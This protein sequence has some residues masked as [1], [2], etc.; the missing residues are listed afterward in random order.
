MT[1]GGSRLARPVPLGLGLF[2]L[3]NSEQVLQVEL[4]KV[5]FQYTGGLHPDLVGGAPGC[6]FA[7]VGILDALH[8]TAGAFQDLQNLAQLDFGRVSG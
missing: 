3:L 5:I 1:A 8:Q 2:L 7:E 4:F 6:P